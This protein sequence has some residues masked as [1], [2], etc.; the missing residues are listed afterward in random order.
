MVP[1]SRLARFRLRIRGNYAERTHAILACDKHLNSDARSVN[2][3]R[4]VTLATTLRRSL[5]W[6]IVSY[7]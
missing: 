1:P 6:H 3:G 2:P 7:L 4:R 5:K